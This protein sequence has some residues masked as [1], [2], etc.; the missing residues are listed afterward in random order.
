MCAWNWITG[1]AV[2]IIGEKKVH[3]VSQ[4]QAQEIRDG[5]EN[6]YFREDGS[7]RRD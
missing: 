7:C 2:S 3:D 4:H 5:I 1:A 6:V